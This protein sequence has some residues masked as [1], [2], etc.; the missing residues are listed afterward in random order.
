MKISSESEASGVVDVVCDV[1]GES[2]RVGD[3]LHFATLQACWRQGSVH[4]GEDYELHL[5]EGCFFSQVAGMKRMRWLNVMFED[6]G[7]D[8]LQDEAYGRIE[9]KLG[10]DGNKEG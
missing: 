6:K 5:C 9:R 8:V 4:S 1:C 7:D 2:T 3:V 10:R